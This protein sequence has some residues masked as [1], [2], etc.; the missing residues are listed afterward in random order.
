MLLGKF[1]GEISIIVFV[2]LLPLSLIV[3]GDSCLIENEILQI[4]FTR[5]Q[6]KKEF[7]ILS[8]FNVRI[9]TKI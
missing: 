5:E 6:E 2:P 7:E 4:N 8:H 3:M 9:E 1:F